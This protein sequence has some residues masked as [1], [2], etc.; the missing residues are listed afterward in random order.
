MNFAQRLQVMVK[1]H[2]ANLQEAHD[3]RVKEAEA[4]AKAKMAR[5]RTDNERKLAKLQLEREKLKLRKDLYEAKIAT[6]RAR[7]AV[8]KARLEAGDLTVGE[9]LTE[10]GRISMKTYRTLA[11]GRRTGTRR[12]ATR[13]RA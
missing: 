11:K 10:F 1:K 6:Q 12:K 5:A 7:D 3:R 4:R 8:K 2:M 13:R 9:R